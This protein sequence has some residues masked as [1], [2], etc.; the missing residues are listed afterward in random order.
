MCLGP[1]LG[2]GVTV[3]IGYRKTQ[4]QNG[5]VISSYAKDFGNYPKGSRESSVDIEQGSHIVVCVRR[6]LLMQGRES[7]GDRPEFK[8]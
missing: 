5:W 3:T 2:F 6:A 1:M 8:S 7:S 4:K